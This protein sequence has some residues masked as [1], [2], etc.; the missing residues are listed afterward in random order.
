MS[1]QITV[2]EFL[3]VREHV[4]EALKEGSQ[5]QKPTRVRQ[6]EHLMQLGLIDIPAV[7]RTLRPEESFIDAVT[8]FGQTRVVEL[9]AED[10]ERVRA[11]GKDLGVLAPGEPYPE[12]DMTP[13]EAD[14]DPH[15]LPTE[16]EREIMAKRRQR[17]KLGDS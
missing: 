6:A 14:G 13:G 1:A 2:D 7:L 15:G 9:S 8:K 17:A 12:V 4:A 3:A 5:T 11:I 16:R 10:R